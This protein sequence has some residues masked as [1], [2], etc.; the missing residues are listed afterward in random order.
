MNLGIKPLGNVLFFLIRLWED[1]LS[2]GNKF[3]HEG[4]KTSEPINLKLLQLFAAFDLGQFD[5]DGRVE[6]QSGQFRFFTNDFG[7]VAHLKDG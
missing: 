7:F 1:Q 2:S 4:A 5:D 6:P 3:L